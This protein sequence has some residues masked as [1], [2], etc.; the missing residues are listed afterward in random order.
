[1]GSVSDNKISSA[2]DK[3]LLLDQTLEIAG[4]ILQKKEE[5]DG[6]GL[7]AGAAGITLL[8]AYLSKTFPDKDYLQVTGDFL[9]NLSEALAN[10]VQ[11]HGLSGGVAG[12]AFVFQHLRNIG[13]LDV[14]EDLNLSELDEFICQAVESEFQNASWDPLH[15]MVGLGIYFL[16]RNTETGE[17]K[18]L[19]KIV[20]HLATMRTALGENM[21]WITPGFGK[22]SNDNYNFGMAHGMPGI[23]SFLAQVHTRGI[24]QAEIESMLASCIPFLLQ[25]EL[26]D[27]GAMVF[28]SSLDVIAANE[29]KESYSR[30]AWCYGDLCVANALTHCGK[31]LPGKGWKEKGIE[32]ALKTTQRT[33]DNSGCADASFCHGSVGIAHQYRRLYKYTKNEEFKMAAE[34]WLHLTQQHYYKPGEGV[35]GY[36]YRSFNA[37]TDSFEPVKEYGLLEGSAGI[38]LVYLSF[39]SNIKPDWDIIFLTNV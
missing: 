13:V 39:L 36:F 11:G 14:S 37:Q 12:I 35:G 7:L 33:F 8:Y 1:M 28:P 34:N 16:E 25:N 22:Y 2:K 17:K 10:D 30:L 29:K 31:I 26:L 18:Y 38:A 6:T 9:D 4:E 20:E 19:E 5:I 23:L 24:K 21:V 15:G 27:G 32:V 3:Q